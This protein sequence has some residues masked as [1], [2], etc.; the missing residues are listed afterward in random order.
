MM[1]EFIK[2]WNIKNKI[3]KNEQTIKFYT[4][5]VAYTILYR[6]V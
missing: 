6:L 3:T 1:Q 5:M 2:E 4:N